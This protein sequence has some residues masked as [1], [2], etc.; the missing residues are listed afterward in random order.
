MT[1]KLFLGLAL[2]LFLINFAAAQEQ[3]FISKKQNT[4]VLSVN[5][6]DAV[7]FNIENARLNNIVTKKK[8]IFAENFQL[9][10]E[11]P[12][13]MKSILPQTGVVLT[14]YNK[15]GSV[16]GKH[17]WYS[18]TKGMISEF[19]KDKLQIVLNANPKLAGASSYTLSMAPDEDE[20]V[21]LAQCVS[22]AKDA[23]GAGKIGSVG[24]T[25]GGDCNFTCSPNQ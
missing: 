3:T 13:V 23:C 18:A 10:F 15:D 14:A 4:N 16:F 7:A 24:T 19:S 22:A 17:I 6:Q 21:T 1:K 20:P 12:N 25:A 5:T 8:G 2:V 11:L 9:S